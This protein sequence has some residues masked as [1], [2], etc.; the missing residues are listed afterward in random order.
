MSRKKIKAKIKQIRNSIAFYYHCRFRKKRLDS[1]YFYTLHKC[2]STLFS[3][4]VLKNAIGL[5]NI[6]Y[7]VE[8]Y[9]GRRGAQKK[10]SFEKSGA[11]YGP[12]RLSADRQ[13][14]VGELLVGPTTEQDFVRDKTAI[15]LIRDPR[16]ILVSAYYSFGFT[17]GLS[18]VDAISQKQ[19]DLME[20]IREL[21]LDEYVLEAATAQIDY[22]RMVNELS[23]NCERSVVLRYEDMI[24]DF[25]RFA[26]QLCKYVDLRPST[27]QEI[28]RRSRPKGVEDMKSHRRSGKAGG[29]R[30][31]LKEGTVSALND[32][33]KDTL[34]LYGYKA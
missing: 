8:I 34:D 14:P 1:V 29:F 11:I 7:A 9:S 25:D 27:I 32:K 19:K 10:L 21:T 4:Y 23:T 30:T 31:K 16:D 28:R 3:G 33:L 2:A 15:L 20:H 22:F 26:E 6:D 17:H 12:I 13:G 5:W 24:D 18:Q